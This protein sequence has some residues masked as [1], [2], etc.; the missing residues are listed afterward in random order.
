MNSIVIRLYYEAWVKS[1][2]QPGRMLQLVIPNI[3]PLLFV[4]QSYFSPNIYRINQHAYRYTNTRVCM[5]WLLRSLSFTDRQTDWRDT[6]Y[7]FYSLTGSLKPRLIC[8]PAWVYRVCRFVFSL[9]NLSLISHVICRCFIF[10]MII[11]FFKQYKHIQTK[12]NA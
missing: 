8:V 5:C 9:V 7:L 10:G 6:N 12:D 1:D 3:M 11:L 4:L 2:T